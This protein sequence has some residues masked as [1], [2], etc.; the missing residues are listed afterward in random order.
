MATRMLAR[1]LVIVLTSLTNGAG[2]HRR[3]P[4]IHASSSA[5]AAAADLPQLLLEQIGDDRRRHPRQRPAGLGG[6]RAAGRK[7]V[8]SFL[9]AL[10]EERCK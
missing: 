1:W 7:T 4:L 6:R 3:G 10:G 9:D 5:I 8:E 2:R